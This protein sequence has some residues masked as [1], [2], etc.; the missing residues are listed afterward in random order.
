[1]QI[2]KY[3]RRPTILLFALVLF[4]EIIAMGLLASGRLH[5]LIHYEPAAKPSLIGGPFT[6]LNQDGETVTNK[7]LKGHH[8]LLF[9]GYS[10]EPDVTP[11][12][13]RVL[14]ATLILLSADA[15]RFKTYFVTLDPERDRP[16]VLKSYLGAIAPEMT[17]LTG[18]PEQIAAIAKAYHVF[19]RKI[20]NPKGGP[21]YTMDY[22]PLIYWMGPDEKFIKPFAYTT[23]AKSLAEG[24]K[25]VLE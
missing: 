25:L 13:L 19:Y 10:N 3:I 17:G 15:A 18:T 1:M 12:E 23:D 22:S 16:D 8:S 20:P 7:D 14:S 4:F 9:F 11:T 5:D 21:D 2:S 24:V 6:L